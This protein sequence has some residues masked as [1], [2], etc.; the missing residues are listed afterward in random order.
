MPVEAET[1]RYGLGGRITNSSNG[2]LMW[3]LIASRQPPEHCC[4]SIESVS[5]RARCTDW[6]TAYVLP[7]HTKLRTCRSSPLADTKCSATSALWA[8]RNNYFMHLHFRRDGTVHSPTYFIKPCSHPLTNNACNIISC[9]VSVPITATPKM[10]SLSPSSSMFHF[11]CPSKLGIYHSH[12]I[13]VPFLRGR[14][15]FSAKVEIHLRHG[16]K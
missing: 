14:L 1:L 16:M 10:F 3:C 11:V 2:T 12:L 13:S 4:H 6:R 9:Y 7:G 8:A 5:V 15:R